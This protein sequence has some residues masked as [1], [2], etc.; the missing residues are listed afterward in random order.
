M[1]IVHSKYIPFKGYVAINL[2]GVI[3]AR[4]GVRVS[5]RTI[6]H[7][8]IHT[9]QMREMGYLPFYLWYVV[10]WLVRLPLH[11]NAYRN[12]AFEREA[13]GFMGDMDYLKRRRHYAWTGMLRHRKKEQ[14]LNKKISHNA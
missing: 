13:Y 8:R 7:E 2:F 6:N 11:G 12:I 14:S 1:K 4:R 3:V 9:A 5:R 10:E